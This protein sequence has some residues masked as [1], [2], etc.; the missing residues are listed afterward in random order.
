MCF[1]DEPIPREEKVAALAVASPTSKFERVEIERRRIG[2]YDVGINILYS[3]ICHSDIHEARDEWKQFSGGN[4]YPL[5]PG[6]EG[7]KLFFF[8]QFKSE[9]LQKLVEA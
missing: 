5:V 7:G 1:F 6:H 8:F 2:E 9:S 4:V 3:G